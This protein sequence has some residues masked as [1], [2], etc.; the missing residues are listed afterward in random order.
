[1]SV[2]LNAV[3]H[4]DVGRWGAGAIPSWGQV[5][6]RRRVLAAAIR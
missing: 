6:K 1:M 3:K 4:L 2:M 5:L